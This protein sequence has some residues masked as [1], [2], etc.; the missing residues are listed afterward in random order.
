MSA[1]VITNNE[2]ATSLSGSGR[3]EADSTSSCESS[4]IESSLRSW[5][6]LAF[7]TAAV[8]S[9]ANPESSNPVASAGFIRRSRR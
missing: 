9:A 5:M 7:A 6:L 1:S 2:L 3:F 8:G 4:S